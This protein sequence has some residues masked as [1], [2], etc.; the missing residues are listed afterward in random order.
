MWFCGWSVVWSRC[1]AKLEETGRK[2]LETFR[3]V[4]LRLIESKGK[5]PHFD[6]GRKRRLFLS[7]FLTYDNALLSLRESRLR[8]HLLVCFS[9]VRVLCQTAWGLS[10]SGP[11]NAIKLMEWNGV[12]VIT[13]GSD[14][15]WWL[16]STSLSYGELLVLHFNSKRRDYR[17]FTK[18]R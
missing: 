8:R 2:S 18:E 6:K 16:L 9:H 11:V 4:C 12:C 13:S 14:S 7:S 15:D 17:M 5:W 3:Q 10:L 1:N